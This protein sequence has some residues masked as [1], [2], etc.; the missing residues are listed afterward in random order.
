ME[1]IIIITVR[2]TIT[3]M[4]E[5]RGFDKNQIPYNRVY[6]YLKDVKRLRIPKL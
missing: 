6:S 2:N 4:M 3:E 1:D 5:D